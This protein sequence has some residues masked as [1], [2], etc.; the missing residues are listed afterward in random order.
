MHLFQSANAWRVQNWRSHFIYYW[1]NSRSTLIH[2]PLPSPI[3]VSDQQIVSTLNSA[4]NP[5]PFRN[6]TMWNKFSIDVVSANRVSSLTDRLKY[7]DLGKT[8][9]FF[10]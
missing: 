1:N 3:L 9:E 2:L 7:S 5:F 10:Y 4:Y 6:I 8:Y